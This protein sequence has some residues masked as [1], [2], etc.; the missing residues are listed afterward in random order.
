MR[1]WPKFISSI[2]EIEKVVFYHQTDQDRKMDLHTN[3][4]GIP[5]PSDV[6]AAGA[7]LGRPRDAGSYRRSNASLDTGTEPHLDAEY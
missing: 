5:I 7:S 4:P 1:Y 6:V 3:F 2:N